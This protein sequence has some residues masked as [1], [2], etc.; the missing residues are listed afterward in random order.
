MQVKPGADFLI[1]SRSA[2]NG[3][4]GEREGKEALVPRQFTSVP[5]RVEWLWQEDN[6]AW[7]K[8]NSRNSKN[9]IYLHAAFLFADSG[10]EE[11]ENWK[12]AGGKVGSVITTGSLVMWYRINSLI[13]F[14]L[15]MLFTL[16]SAWWGK[17][18]ALLPHDINLTVDFSPFFTLFLGRF[19]VCLLHFEQ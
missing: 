7:R 13:H 12:A 18:A 15:F 1:D 6:C 17:H 2:A 9:Y 19:L 11:Y 14:I 5:L 3:R 8:S 4:P 10:E 16:L